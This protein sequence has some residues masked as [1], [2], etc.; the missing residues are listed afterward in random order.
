ME[1]VVDRFAL[2][3]ESGFAMTV[4]IESFAYELGVETAVTFSYMIR[5]QFYTSG[6]KFWKITK[7]KHS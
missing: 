5:F 6:M 3:K 4:G 1:N 2:V 7:T